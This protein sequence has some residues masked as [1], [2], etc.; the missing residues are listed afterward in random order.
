M[1]NYMYVAC[2]VLPLISVHLA[3][4]NPFDSSAFQFLHL[5]QPAAT[6]TAAA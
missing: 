2:L 4:T 1:F 6:T 3:Q 5:P